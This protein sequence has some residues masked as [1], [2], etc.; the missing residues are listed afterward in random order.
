[1]LR[2]SSG[3]L[4]FWGQDPIFLPAL[5]YRDPPKC[6]GVQSLNPL[7]RD[8]LLKLAFPSGPK[9]FDVA[10]RMDQTLF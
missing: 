6:F 8:K 7:F 10:I 2:K 3:T 4:K 9:Q 5:S 1:M